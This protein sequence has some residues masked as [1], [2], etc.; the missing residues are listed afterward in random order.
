MSVMFEIDFMYIYLSMHCPI[1]AL[2]SVSA[3]TQ[4]PDGLPVFFCQGHYKDRRTAAQ[5]HIQ[6]YR[7]F[8]VVSWWVVL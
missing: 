3:A 8:R 2:P 6:A 7:P 1:T 4:T 5:A